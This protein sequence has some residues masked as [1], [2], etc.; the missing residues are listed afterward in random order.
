MNYYK[1]FFKSSIHL[2]ERENF[3]EST[4]VIIHSDTL[5]SAFCNSYLLL[6]GEEKLNKLLSKF[7]EGSPP[8]IISSAFPWWEDK[9]YFPIPLNQI[10]KDKKLKK[11]KFIEKDAFEKLL[12]GEKLENL[13]SFKTIPDITTDD[14][15]KKTPYK[16]VT[17]PR[18]GLSR[19]NNHPGENF[20]HFSE[21]FYRENSGLFFLVDF[22]DES[23]RNEF[24]ATL[25]LMGEE[26]IGGDRTV[27][28]GIF[29]VI[30]TNEI[31][32]NI[33]V[34]VTPSGYITL[35]LYCP[36]EDELK[37]LDLNKSYY[38]IIERKGYIFSPFCKSYRKKSIRMFV[39]GSIFLSC[40]TGKIV[41]ITPE[42]FKKHKVY[43]YGFCMGIL[44]K[45]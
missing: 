1:L 28:K 19:L 5:F 41:D 35:S 13:Q 30:E 12:N 3:L 22:K 27:G 20:F 21:V 16:I 11:I 42:T 7:I 37:D 34:S 38:D 45:L 15:D 2:G 25:R 40:K 18:V 23:I 33:N 17:T 9:F 14:E 26:G 29:E 31:G 4:D 8:F 39:E 6:Y 10:P 44:C 43:R 36:K 24:E 32:F